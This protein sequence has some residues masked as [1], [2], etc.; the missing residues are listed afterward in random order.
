MAFSVNSDKVSLRL[1]MSGEGFLAIEVDQIYR[2]AEGHEQ[3]GKQVKEL[4]CRT[5]PNGDVYV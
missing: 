5:S 2:P 3:F 1:Q 4:T